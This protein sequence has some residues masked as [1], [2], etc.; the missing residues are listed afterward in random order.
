MAKSDCIIKIAFLFLMLTFLK[1]IFFLNV[2]NLNTEW[3]NFKI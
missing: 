3:K 1:K 2:I